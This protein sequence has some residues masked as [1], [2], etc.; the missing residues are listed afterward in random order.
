[1]FLLW[2]LIA[3][4]IRYFYIYENRVDI[5][6]PLY[7]HKWKTIYNQ[8]ILRI[9]YSGG[10]A[11]GVDG[12]EIFILNKKKRF[13]LPVKNGFIVFNVEDKKKVLNHFHKL[14]IPI[15]IYSQIEEDQYLIER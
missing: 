12:P 1:M 4:E 8:D 2:L 11:I 10:G 14:N 5:Y 15:K 6:H 3:T 7:H 13:F 9:H